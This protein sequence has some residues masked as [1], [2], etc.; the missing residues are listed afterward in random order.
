MRLVIYTPG[1]SSRTG[2]KLLI[3]I[4]IVAIMFVFKGHVS[5]DICTVDPLL[6]HHFILVVVVGVVEGLVVSAC[7]T[8]FG[9]VYFVM[10][11]AYFI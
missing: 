8:L 7:F 4:V 6:R 3:N 2:I 9:K 11:W 10:G 5:S 1:Y